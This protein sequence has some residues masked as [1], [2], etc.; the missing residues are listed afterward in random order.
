MQDNLDFLMQSVTL[1][2]GGE[3]RNHLRTSAPQDLIAMQPIYYPIAVV[4]A[5]SKSNYQSS[6]RPCQRLS[7]AVENE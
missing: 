5:L 3:A 7:A 1:A 6:T 2:F 4:H